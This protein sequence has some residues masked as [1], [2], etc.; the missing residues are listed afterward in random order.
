MRG[1][2]LMIA[3]NREV[4]RQSAARYA[5]RDAA[6][7]ADIVIGR[8][9]VV[10]EVHPFG[11]WFMARW[12]GAEHLMAATGWPEMWTRSGNLIGVLHRRGSR[13][14]GYA[15]FSPSGSRLATLATGLST[16][17]ADQRYDDPAIGTFSY[18]TGNGDLLRTDG[19]AMSAIAST[20]ALGFTSVPY[21]GILCGGLVQLLSVSA[22]W[23]EGQVILYQDGQL[24]TR[25]PE[26]RGQVAGF[27]GL[28]ASPSRH[29][30]TYIP[31]NDSGN[32][33]TI[34][35][36]RP[37]SAPVAV[38]RT[39]RG[40]SPCAPPPLAWHGTVVAAI[41]RC[42]LVSECECSSSGS[43]SLRRS[44]RGLVQRGLVPG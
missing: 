13:S 37:G 8:P 23:R 19:V 43:L 10:F 14:F 5:V 32:G 1:G 24:F 33:S 4:I 22:N 11:P 34:F 16:S 40:A 31:T 27:G 20:R 44:G 18:L 21:F 6:H 2:Y 35:L 17:G 42:H 39:A 41:H 26:P 29:M 15:V 28:S 3:R 7:M 38:Y 9:G 36:V 25:T 12:H 30:V